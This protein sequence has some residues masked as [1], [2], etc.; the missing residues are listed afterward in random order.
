MHSTQ[1]RTCNLCEAVCGLAIDLQGKQIISIRGDSAD[2]FSLGHICPKAASLP[3][4]YCDPDRLTQPQQRE[5]NT[6]HT[7]PWSKALNEVADRIASIQ[8]TYG[9]D[10]V[11]I[12]LGNPI[13]HDYASMFF[14]KLFL[15]ALRTRNRFSALSVDGLPHALTSYLMFGHQMLIPVP[16]LDRTEFFLVF[17]ANPLVSN[18]SVMTAPAFHQRLRQLRSKGGK[19]VVI[20]P[21]R[22]ETAKVADT[23]LFIKPGTDAL[24]LLS[25]I[26]VIFEEG[27]SDLG[28]L[29]GFTDG[30][31]DIRG[32]V[33]VFRAETVAPTVGI[34][35][36]TIRTLAREFASAK[37]A[38]CYGRVGVSTQEFGVLACWLIN[39]LNIVTGNLDRIGGSMF[40]RPAVDLVTLTSWTGDS[41]HFA[42]FRSRVRGLPE[43]AGELP[44]AVLAE[45]I[46]T[47]GSQQI[48]G[49]ITF[50]GNPVLSS[51]NGTRL[52]RA[53]GKL[54]F[55]VSVDLY[56][57]ETTKHADFILPPSS[58]L[59]RDHFPLLWHLFAIRNTAKYSP[60]VF[61][62][63]PNTLHDWQILFEIQKRL[64]KRRMLP[65]ALS[66][67]VA[68][69]LVGW[70][71]PERLLDFFLRIGPYGLNLRKLKSVPHGIDLGPLTACLPKRLKTRSRRI[72]LTPKPFL[73]DIQRLTS[74]I[75]HSNPS[76]SDEF[77]LIGRRQSRTNNTWMHN[78][79]RLVKGPN[80]CT[81]LM[82]PVDAMECGLSD[83]QLVRVTSRT[84]SLV[85]PLEF[86]ETIM[87][88]VVSLPHGW[89]HN[90]TGCKLSV[91]SEHPGVSVNDITDDTLVDELAG[92]ARFSGIKITI[93]PAD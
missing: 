64:D 9:H 32:L 46:E 4:I 58:S 52:E 6:W 73:A 21:R 51:P 42:R 45:E 88:G 28:R 26:S 60:P 82:H 39:V 56:R 80:T 92:T 70:L 36:K 17:G 13:A 84:G 66:K 41:G 34:D 5:N 12:Y 69:T 37:S 72:Q 85:V 74:R 78:Y 76:N 61:Q 48:R 23:H 33:D 57:N 79:Y 63:T 77:L 83:D 93:S 30:L 75:S 44:V 1:F 86:C 40:T 2:R 53:L 38:V 49:L 35:A 81:L 14:I 55:M 90:R 47:T 62:P 29:A 7:V 67:W 87:R 8:A 19:L 15:N 43:F 22:T 25:L 50:A 65:V 68:N 89:G 31:D 11:A 27:L 10:S 16:D 20:D 24:L 71:G 59:E 3:D 54:D 18:G 91:A